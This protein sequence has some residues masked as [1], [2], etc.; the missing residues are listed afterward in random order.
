MENEY[1]I[2]YNDTD[3]MEYKCKKRFEYITWY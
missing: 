1:I 3:F 2:M